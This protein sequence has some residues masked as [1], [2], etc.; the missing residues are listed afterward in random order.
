[1]PRSFL[2]NQN[3]TSQLQVLACVQTEHIDATFSPFLLWGYFYFHCP[4][5][6]PE[7]NEEKKNH[8]D[9]LPSQSLSTKAQQHSRQTHLAFSSNN[10]ESLRRQRL[11]SSLPYLWLSID[12]SLALSELQQWQR[13]RQDH[14]SKFLLKYSSC[15]DCTRHCLIQKKLW[16]IKQ[17]YSYTSSNIRMYFQA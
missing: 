2:K 11:H 6:S 14:Q 16:E 4:F 10:T 9:C 12:P 5:S 3:Q 8:G 1:M 13:G 15:K 7:E 17:F